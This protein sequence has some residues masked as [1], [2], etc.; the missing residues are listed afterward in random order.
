ME[1]IR[2]NEARLRKMERMAAAGRLASSLAHE[3]NNPL[4]AVMNVIYLLENHPTLDATARGFVTMGGKELGRVA[5][6]VHQ[7]LSYHHTG[8]QPCDFDVSEVVN[9]S[10]KILASRFQRAGIRVRPRIQPGAVVFGI[11]D[12]IRQVL[13]NLL[14]NAAEAMPHGG[15][16][17]ISVSPCRD[18]SHPRQKGVRLMI[19]DSGPGIPR[20]IRSQIFEAF[21]TTKHE[22]GTGLGLWVTAGVV[23]KH[24][25][26]VRLRTSNAEGRSG[27]VFSIFFPSR[28]IAKG[29]TTGSD[30]AA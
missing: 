2:Q 14:L 18:W 21:F 17:A 26:T 7:M 20:E 6:I 24:G 3:I 28:P 27:T 16:L 30:A 12:E 1:A 25:G 23:S 22:K 9:D 11:S 10:L 5:R 13:D 29:E 8:A 19:A 4:A 15:Q